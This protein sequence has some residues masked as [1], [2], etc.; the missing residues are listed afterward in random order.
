MSDKVVGRSAD[1]WSEF[2][3]SKVLAGIV[4]SKSRQDVQKFLESIL[5]AR[6]R[7]F[8]L[9]RLAILALL[10]SGKSYKEIGRILWV[11]PQTVSAI[12]KNFS[13]KAGQYK[14]HRK[15]N[16]MKKRATSPPPISSPAIDFIFAFLSIPVKVFEAF[17]IPGIGV[18]G[19]R[20][21]DKFR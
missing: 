9:R 2:L 14:S 21:F 4:G 19:D 13:G 17:L 15:F 6:E 5:S 20:Y 18:T 10:R 1:E 7:K 8:L 16:L 11:S 12:K 3:W